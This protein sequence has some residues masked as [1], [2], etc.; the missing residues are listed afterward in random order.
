MRGT[1]TIYFPTQGTY[2]FPLVCTYVHRRGGHRWVPASGTAPSS[3][4]N[5]ARQALHPAP[6][7]SVASVPRLGRQAQVLCT[8]SIVLLP[9]VGQ[10]QTLHV[11]HPTCRYPSEPLLDRGPPTGLDALKLRRHRS[12]KQRVLGSWADIASTPSGGLVGYGEPKTR[13]LSSPHPSGAR[14]RT[15]QRAQGFRRRVGSRA[16]SDAW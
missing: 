2:V 15:S 5:V 4:G 3:A 8:W 14:T 11:D 16:S 13:I 1:L 7:D 10:A 6:T 9:V 12:T